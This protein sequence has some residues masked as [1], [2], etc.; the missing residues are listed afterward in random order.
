[1]RVPTLEKEDEMSTDKLVTAEQL[2]GALKMAV[3]GT[4]KKP[5]LMKSAV[6]HMEL[7]PSTWT[8]SSRPRTKANG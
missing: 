8:I 5:G 4:K 6:P 3:E 1:M 2:A 7:I